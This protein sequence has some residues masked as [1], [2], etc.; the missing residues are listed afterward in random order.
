MPPA[1]CQRRHLILGLIAVLLH[2]WPG[3]EG[4]GEV[5]RPGPIERAPPTQPGG[6]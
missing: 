1:L 5:D 4:P 3:A 2:Y 6:S